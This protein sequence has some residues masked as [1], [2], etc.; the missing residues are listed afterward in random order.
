M[1][2]SFGYGVP[3]LAN[4]GI[5]GYPTPG[6]AALDTATTMRAALRA[7]ALGYD[8]LWVADHLMLGRDDAILEGWTVV[9]ALAGATKRARLGVLHQSNLLRHPALAAKMAATLDQLSGGRLIYYPDAGNNER[10][11]RAYGLPWTDDADG[12]I[13]R[14]VEAL[15]LTL[16]L[17]KGNEAVTLT[18]RYYQL[19]GAVCVPGPLQRPHPPIWMGGTHPGILKVCAQFAQGWHS[20]PVSLA[21]LAERL[22]LLKSAFEAAGRDM[23][24]LEK[25]MAIP[26]LVAPDH[27]E[28]R[29]QLSSIIALEP[30][31]APDVELQAYLQG[32]QSEL[33]ASFAGNRLVGTPEEV[34]KQVRAYIDAGIDHFMLWFMDS[35]LSDSLELF[36]EKVVPEFT[37]EED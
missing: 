24:E 23:A 7:E 5:R 3:V 6:Y 16:A 32:A 20:T 28:L 18:G 37:Q 1:A 31:V 26:V 14:M 17:W 11:H 35:P 29:R 9:S 30:D 19:D 25:A 4:P 34:T 33:P 36:A 13:A 12:R 10:E 27:G 22:V 21:Q 2:V 15:E 8:T